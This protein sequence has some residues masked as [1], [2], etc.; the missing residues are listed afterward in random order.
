MFDVPLCTHSQLHLSYVIYRIH[1]SMLGILLLVIWSC[2]PC[3]SEGPKPEAEDF[4]WT[5]SQKT[6]MLLGSKLSKALTVGRRKVGTKREQSVEYVCAL[7]LINSSVVGVNGDPHFR[8]NQARNI[9]TQI[10]FWFA[11]Q[12]FPLGS[13]LYNGTRCNIEVFWDYKV[14]MCVDL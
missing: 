3:V 4:T 9:D 5:T 10:T 12:H 14:R 6:S 13:N 8:D 1:I 7:D 11:N 2:N